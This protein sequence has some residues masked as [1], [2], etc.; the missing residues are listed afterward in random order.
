MT[1]IKARSRSWAMVGVA[2]ADHVPG[3]RLLPRDAA[4]GLHRLDG[5]ES[6]VAEDVHHFDGGDHAVTA[7]HAAERRG[8]EHAGDGAAEVI[9]GQG[10]GEG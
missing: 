4:A 8:G 6:T 3:V 7:A 9:A 10:A 5:K 2:E 1:A